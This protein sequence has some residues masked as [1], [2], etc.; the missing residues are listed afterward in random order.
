MLGTSIQLAGSPLNKGFPLFSFIINPR[1]SR[2]TMTIVGRL[3][4]GDILME[5]HYA[6]FRG[7]T[8]CTISVTSDY[9][10][11]NQ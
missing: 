6:P 8:K 10:R 2:T 9:R 5:E 11:K 7:G 3:I 4:P 1:F